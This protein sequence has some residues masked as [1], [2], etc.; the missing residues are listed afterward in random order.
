MKAADFYRHLETG[1][2]APVYLFVGNAELQIEE[3]W[4]RLLRAIVP[5]SARRFNGERLRAREIPAAQVLPL[6]ETLPM[7]GHRRL[8]MV[9]HIENWAK[10]QQKLLL[11]YIQKPIPTACLALTLD[12]A[13]GMEK[14]EAAVEAVGI[15]VKFASLTEWDAPRWLQ[16]R[17]RGQGKQLTPKAAAF[18]TEWVGLDEQALGQE[19]EKVILFTG[20]SAT[21]DLAEVQEVA[22]FQRHFS[23]FEMMRLVGQKDT[24]RALTALSQ[25][26]LAGEAP[27]AILGLLARQVR[28][29]WQV[30]DGM[31]RGMGTSELGRCLNLYPKILNQY[32]D[33]ARAFS[34][35]RLEEFHEAIRTSD[36]LLKS[37]GVSPEMILE[38]LIVSMCL[39]QTNEPP[40][41]G[42]RGS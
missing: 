24:S 26:L 37:S 33:Q 1:A 15:V 12:H 35:V 7:F 19:L 17:A 36:V 27:L 4:S 18:L 42:S 9:Q 39:P 30:K 29:I 22:S 16:N 21:I 3:A 10:D 41:T 5:E 40:D 13:K 28:L 14:L 38:S 23:S 8:V 31:E 25:L 32:V 2:L 11:A 6:L 20:E 34:Q